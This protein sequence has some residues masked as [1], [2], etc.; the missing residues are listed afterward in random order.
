MFCVIMYHSFDANTPVYVF[1]TYEKAKKF[2]DRT[3]ENYLNEEIE[4]NS[5]LDMDN[6]F[7]ED[8]FAKV[9]WSDGESTKFI[10]SCTSEPEDEYYEG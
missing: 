6:C 7:H 8:V 5:E 1:P 10:L 4:N 2:F 3:Y 9:T